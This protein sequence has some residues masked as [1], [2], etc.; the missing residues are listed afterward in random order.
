MSHGSWLLLCK[1]PAS[2]RALPSNPDL[3]RSSGFYSASLT[4]PQTL[5]PTLSSLY[6]GPGSLGIA[7]PG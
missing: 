6:T 4:K 2:S 1:E 7:E 5:N 3:S